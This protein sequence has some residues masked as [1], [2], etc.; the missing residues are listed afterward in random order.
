MK[1][2]KGKLGLPPATISRSRS[3]TRSTWAVPLR[4]LWLS[5]R[6]TAEE[7]L[8]ATGAR[9]MLARAAAT[10]RAYEA[11]LE[12]EGACVRT[13]CESIWCSC[14]FLSFCDMNSATR[15]ASRYTF[16]LLPAPM[17]PFPSRLVCWGHEAAEP[18][19]I[20]ILIRTVGH[21]ANTHQNVLARPGCHMM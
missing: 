16:L 20:S 17:G 21:V 4:A 18:S 3:H 14:S 15:Y 12:L 5:S 13:R 6:R 8:S 7:S 9:D 10:I 2:S 11:P 1:G 19:S